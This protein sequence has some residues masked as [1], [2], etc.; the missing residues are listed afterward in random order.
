MREEPRATNRVECHSSANPPLPRCRAS[1]GTLFVHSACAGLLA[2]LLQ[3]DDDNDDDD[4]DDD[5][6]NSPPPRGEAPQW[7]RAGG[8]YIIYIQFLTYLYDT[9][10]KKNA[11]PYIRHP[12]A[13]ACVNQK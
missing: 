7:G 13:P 2:L 12:R 5:E 3:Y 6:K 4:D 11:Y 9:T 10:Q 8:V 1:F